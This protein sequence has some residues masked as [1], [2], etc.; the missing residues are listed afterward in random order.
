MTYSQWLS[1]VY[2]AIHDGR[3]GE[4]RIGQFLFNNTPDHIANRL[5]GSDK[6]P[7]YRDERILVYLHA[8]K[9]MWSE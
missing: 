3:H 6:D 2:Q 7:F 8:V 4:Q 9:E 5:R 1:V